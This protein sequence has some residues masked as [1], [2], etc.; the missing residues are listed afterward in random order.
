MKTVYIIGDLNL[1]IIL[2]GI[3]ELPTLGREIIARDHIMKAGGSAANVAAVLSMSGCPVRFFSRVGKDI[4][5]S[6]VVKHLNQLGVKTEGI[7]YADEER[8]GVTVALTYPQDRIYITHAGT[9]AST[10]LEDFHGSYLSAD[11]HLHLASFFLQTGLGPSMGEILKRAKGCGM[12]TSLDPGGDTSR[13]WDMSSL[14]HALCSIDWFLPNREE[15][16][17]ITKTKDI[18]KALKIFPKEVQGVVVKSGG[19][20]AF[21][22]FKGQIEHFPAFSVKVVDASCAGD[23]FD[24][25][26]IYGLVRGDSF[27]EAVK[28]GNRFGA[29]AVSTLGLPHLSISE[30]EG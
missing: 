18:Q 7:T 14:G 27:I 8:T 28:L 24:A 12:S 15:L 10:K 9:V 25:G 2:A 21:V 6:F 23:C 16:L 26:F 30:M 29:E 13:K 17:G 11:G 3:E 19:E 5:G 20:G 4:E 1:D 22:R